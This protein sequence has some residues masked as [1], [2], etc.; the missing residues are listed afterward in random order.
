MEKNVQLKN[1]YVLIDFE[2]K[3][4]P[5]TDFKLVSCAIHLMPQ[6]TKHFFWLY[7]NEEEQNKLFKFLLEHEDAIHVAFNV[8]GAEGLC[9]LNLGLDVMKFKWID[10]QLEWK[11]LINSRDK[12]NSGKHLVKGQ[13]K[14]IPTVRDFY[15]YKNNKKGL[16]KKYGVNT[17]GSPD[18]SLAAMTYKLLGVDVDLFKKNKMRDLIIYTP[19]FTEENIKAIRDYN[20]SD[21]DEM[22]SLLKAAKGARYQLSLAKDDCFNMRL[23]DMLFRGRVSA[24]TSVMMH[25]GY[26]V[27]KDDLMNLKNNIPLI[28][29]NAIE[30]MIANGHNLFKD[31]PKASKQK[32]EQGF[33]YSRDMKAW[34]DAISKS[35]YV[36]NWP[37]TDTG[38]FKLDK[39]TLQSFYPFKY[40]F[41]DDNIYAQMIR[42]L[43]LQSSLKGLNKTARGSFFDSVGS[44]N[45]SRPFLNPYGSQTARWQPKATGFMF[46]KSAWMRGA[47]HPEPGKMICGI[48]YASQEILV[49]A[50][51][52]ED[53]G[54]IDAYKSGDI[55]LYYGKKMGVIPKNGTKETHK[56]MRNVCK[57]AVLGIGFGM[58]AAKLSITMSEASGKKMSVED[59]QYFIDGYYEVFSDY[60]DYREELEEMYDEGVPIELPCGWRL[61][62]DNPNRNS[63]L[64]FPVQGTASTILRVATIKAVEAGLELLFPLHDALYCEMKV[65]DFD[66]VKKLDN[67]MKE[68]CVEVL[69][70]SGKLMRTDV[71]VWGD[72]IKKPLA[73]KNYTIYDRY[74]DKRGE[75]E[76]N[77]Y[78]KYFKKSF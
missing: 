73:P 48:D 40:N 9:Y 54:L 75:A 56:I 10:L 25:R 60:G 78:K 32:I 28:T 50:C 5:E 46:L 71:D 15:R 11:Q 39:E 14:T 2:Y 69:G 37:K 12:Y 53:L 27:K 6:N 34:Q 31:L 13:V 59:A 49:A 30:G 41:P 68:A 38:K 76:F 20:M 26:P 43:S 64:N 21:I 70:P 1:K 57:S 72:D 52:S 63:V 55:Y 35:D 74:L 65:N 36:D 47:V 22:W 33:K 23:S 44:D 17:S 29:N 16:I 8:S 42:F 66:A 4:T 67:I 58:G 61:Y 45:R 51:L 77:N 18:K 19:E 3:Y 62:A 7:K 24:A